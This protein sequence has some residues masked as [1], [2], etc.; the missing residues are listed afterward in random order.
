MNATK[1]LKKDQVVAATR[2]I[3]LKHVTI[4]AE[5]L[6]RVEEVVEGGAAYKVRFMLHSRANADG[7]WGMMDFGLLVASDEVKIAK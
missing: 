2:E 3:G 1:T 5:T 4:P 6:G 7:R